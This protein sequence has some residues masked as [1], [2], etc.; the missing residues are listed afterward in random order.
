MKPD[1]KPKVALVTGASTGI[2]AAIAARLAKAGYRTY[3][4]SRKP[5]AASP[6]HGVRMLQMDVRDSQTIRTCVGTIIDECGRVDVLVNNAGDGI[7][8][9]VEETMPDDLHAQFDTNLYGPL[10]VC[11]AVLPHMRAQNAG[12]IIQITSL[13]ARMAVPFQGAYSA[14]KWALEGLS[15][16]M[17]MELRPFGIDVVMIEPGDTKTGFTSARQWTKTSVQSDVYRLRAKHAVAVMEKSEQAGP[18]ADKVAR[19]VQQAIE[20]RHPRLRYV[21]VSSTERM[22]LALQK[23]LPGRMFESLV[24]STFTIPR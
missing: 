12:R 6:G 17:S 4:T 19:I 3:G 2:G 8:A 10:R 22:A 7:A 9:A 5:D 20:A 23:I 13:T 21:S 11:Q 16:A 15:E 24:S 14:S 18:P 1:L